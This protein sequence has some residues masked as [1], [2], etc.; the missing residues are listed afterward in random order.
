MVK[1][2]FGD[3]MK[4]AGEE[5]RQYGVKGQRWGF[6]RRGT[7]G[8]TPPSTRKKGDSAKEDKP[9]TKKTSIKD[10][11][12]NEL[13][14]R[15]TRLQREKQLAQLMTPEKKAQSVVAEVLK[16]SGRQ[17]ASQVITQVGT[18][19]IKKALSVQLDT[20]LPP[21]YAVGKIPDKD[22]D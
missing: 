14:A 19:Y 17:I 9:E 15:I 20:R 6:R 2:L 1:L 11:S 21:A 7:R 4:S 8:S 18:A 13:Q 10:L 16:T 3:A 5:L 12:D 22:K